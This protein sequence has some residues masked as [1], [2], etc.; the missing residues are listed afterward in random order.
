MEKCQKGIGTWLEEAK[1]DTIS[2]IAPRGMQIPCDGIEICNRGHGEMVR[3]PTQEE[4]IKMAEKQGN[5]VEETNMS[6]ECGRAQMAKCSKDN[7]GTKT[8]RKIEES[9]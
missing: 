7:K 9:V 6:P 4:E 5:K 2:M 3:K 8:G 1:E